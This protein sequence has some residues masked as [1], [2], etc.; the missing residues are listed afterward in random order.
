MAPAGAAAEPARSAA[1]E[2]YP[3]GYLAV[4]EGAIPNAD[5][6]VRRT[7]GGRA[8]RD[9]VREVCDGALATIAVGSCAFDGG[10][11]GAAGG[12]HRRDRRGRRSS[13][14]ATLITLPGL[15]G[16]R[17]EPRRDDRPLPD[18]QGAAGG[19]RAG[20]A[21]CSPTAT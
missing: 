4:V 1:M 3:N 8:F 6:G 13:S 17:R 16:E 14:N 20:P 10:A 9:V 2:R 19:R 11:R 15:P 5:G 18:L 7:V 21:R 12:E